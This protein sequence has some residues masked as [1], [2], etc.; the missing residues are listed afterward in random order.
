MALKYGPEFDA[1]VCVL[2]IFFIPDMVAAA[3]RMWSFVRPGGRLAVTT[4]GAGVFEPFSSRFA[5]AVKSQRPDIEIV[6]PWRRTEDARVLRSTLVQAGVPEVHVTTESSDLPI[7]P[8][9]WWTVVMGSGFRH[10][11]E[12]LGPLAET[13]RKDNEDWARTDRI[14]RIRVTA[15]YAMATKGA[16]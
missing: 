1:V 14:D 6:L 11:A 4:L 5:D 12:Q 10:T 3:S 15:N 9:Y 2:G 7:E 8:E 16:D 13:V